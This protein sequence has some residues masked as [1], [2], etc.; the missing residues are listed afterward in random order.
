MI[1]YNKILEYFLFFNIFTPLTK[2]NVQTIKK[3]TVISFFKKNQ[4][5][6]SSR[7]L[8]VSV[9]NV[10]NLITAV[11]K[12]KG[13]VLFVGTSKEIQRFFFFFKHRHQSSSSSFFFMH[14]WL[15]GFL[16]NWALYQRFIAYATKQDNL[17]FTKA[18]KLRFFRFFFSLQNKPK[19]TLV[20]VFD[21]I[22]SANHI[23]VN[24]C[25]IE[26]VPLI[27]LGPGFTQKEF[28]NISY[29][30][31]I[32]ST[33]VYSQW[34]FFQLFFGQLSHLSNAK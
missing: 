4:A 6:S 2:N 16:T 31:Q 9:F 27:F 22:N 1:K 17:V 21:S 32:N 12:Q 29:K 13:T 30:I 5:F 14:K 15:P 19:P 23:I 24:E 34:I 18:K 3:S 20:L 26:S 25:F 11:Y 33:N 28:N 10:I 8:L 7:L